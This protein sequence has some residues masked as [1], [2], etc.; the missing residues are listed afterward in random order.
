MGDLTFS[1]AALLSLLQWSDS[2]FPSG[3][4][5]HSFG[6]ESAV[7]EKEVQNGPDLIQWIRAKLTHQIFPCDL[8]LLRQAYDAAL[9]NNIEAL[10]K[11]DEIAHAMRLPR[12]I[13]EG[14]SM[15]AFRMIQTGAEL[16]PDTFM[17]SCFHLF[18]KKQLKGDPALAFALVAYA[19]KIPL[20]AASFAFCYLFI[21]GQ[22]SASLRL[23]PIGQQEGQRLIHVLLTWLEKNEAMKRAMHDEAVAPQS[24]MPASEIASMQ[25]ETSK[26]RL[27]QS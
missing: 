22:V 1:P 20:E 10:Q 18:S 25:H 11:T 5:S 3:A 8:I 6:L 9:K 17:T 12:E 26:V 7:D 23:L 27:F 13:R 14:G 15:I 16:Y 19:A 2:L 24:F 21:S 4:F